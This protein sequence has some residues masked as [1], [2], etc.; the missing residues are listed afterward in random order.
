M[1][2]LFNAD[3]AVSKTQSGLAEV[4]E[5]GRYNKNESRHS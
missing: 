4:S 3:E 2:I 5:V 1:K